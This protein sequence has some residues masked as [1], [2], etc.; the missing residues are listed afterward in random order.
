MTKDMCWFIVEEMLLRADVRVK[1]G[2][3]DMLM[4]LKDKTGVTKGKQEIRLSFQVVSKSSYMHVG[5]DLDL[6]VSS[7]GVGNTS[8]DD[9]N[10][11]RGGGRSS[12]GGGSR[13]GGGMDGTSN[14]AVEKP[15]VVEEAPVDIKE[16]PVVETTVEIEQPTVEKGNASA[17]VEKGKAPVVEDKPKLKMKRGR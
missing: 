12:M 9:G 6:G 1:K 10:T 15:V 16:A 13:R 7:W 14:M 3:K 2:N 17:A 11:G 4:P 5:T 8:R